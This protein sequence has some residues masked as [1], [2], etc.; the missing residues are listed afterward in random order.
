MSSVD[1][2]TL[3]PGRGT[4]WQLSFHLIGLNVDCLTLFLDIFHQWFVVIS[5]RV[6]LCTLILTAHLYEYFAG[7][8][9]VMGD[10]LSKIL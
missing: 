10:G 8:T 3:F 5:F 4:K 7:P 2:A 6:M 9:C 1:L